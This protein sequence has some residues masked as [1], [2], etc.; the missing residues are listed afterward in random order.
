MGKSSIL[1]NLTRQFASFNSWQQYQH[2]H[3]IITDKASSSSDK[4][5]V[6]NGHFLNALHNCGGDSLYTRSKDGLLTVHSGSA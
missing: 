6:R 4:D 5:K 1:A 3:Q 2:S